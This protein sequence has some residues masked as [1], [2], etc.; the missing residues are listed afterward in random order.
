M[1]HA[2][3]QRQIYRSTEIY[4]VTSDEDKEFL[5]YR[6]RGE[7]NKTESHITSY[8]AVGWTTG[9]CSQE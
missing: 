3:G 5:R 4:F 2:Y 1:Q 6:Y 9:L 7:A 8:T